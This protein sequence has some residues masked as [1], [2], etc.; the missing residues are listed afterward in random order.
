MR[1]N[2][3]AALAAAALIPTVLVWSLDPVS[4]AVAVPLEVLLALGAGLAPRSLWRRAWLVLLVAPFSALTGLL[5]GRES[6]RHYLDFGLL[7]LTDGSIALAVTIFLRVL[8]LALP[9]V[10][11]VG[12]TDATAL[13][14]ALAQRLRL[15][16]RFVYG[17]LAALRL[18]E[19]LREDAAALGLARRARGVGDGG[20]IRRAAGVSLALFVMSVRRGSSLATAMEAR[21]FGGP[22]P[23]S[24]WR[25]SPWGGRDWALMAAALAVAAASVAIAVAAGA[26]NPVIGGAG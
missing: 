20:R 9:A 17:A 8:A 10:L 18:G 4:A 7:H 5:Y 21:G 25:D 1:C 23:R 15:P 11:L 3:L 2:P 12:G 26:W 6:G 19:V 14:D 16:Q 22:T 24:F 13:A